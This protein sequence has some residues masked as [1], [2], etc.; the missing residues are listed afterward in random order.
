MHQAKRLVDCNC[1]AKTTVPLAK[2]QVRQAKRL[3]D[4][5]T[6]GEAPGIIRRSAWF[7]QL[8]VYAQS[9]RRSAWL[10][11]AKRLVSAI[12]W[13]DEGQPP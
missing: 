13:D 3:V 9:I 7:M 6:S 8:L 12:V 11:Q 4:C 1:I 5:S 10:P 2:R